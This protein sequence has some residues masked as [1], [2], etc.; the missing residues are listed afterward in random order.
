MSPKR[1]EVAGERMTPSGSLGAANGTSQEPERCA[2]DCT[3]VLHIPLSRTERCGAE[4]MRRQEG[5]AAGGMDFDQR[6]VRRTHIGKQQICIQP[7]HRRRKW[8]AVGKMCL[9]ICFHRCAAPAEMPERGF[10]QC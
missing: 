1:T 9:I 4:Q 10:E 6:T 3:Q 7:R 5:A 2:T 8:N